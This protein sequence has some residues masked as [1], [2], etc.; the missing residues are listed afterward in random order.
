MADSLLHE[1]ALDLDHIRT[2]LLRHVQTLKDSAAIDNIGDAVD[3]LA[4][5]KGA[6]LAAQREL[7][8]EVSKESLSTR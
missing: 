8:S 1:T 7:N 6:L 4:F 3:G 2:R 5:V